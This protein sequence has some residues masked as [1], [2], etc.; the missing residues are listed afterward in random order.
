MGV[1]LEGEVPIDMPQPE[2]AVPPPLLAS[3]AIMRKCDLRCK[4]CY[5]DATEHPDADELSTSEAKRLVDDLS[6][7]GV[8]LLVLDGGEPLCRDDLLKDSMRLFRT[9]QRV[10]V[11][12]NLGKMAESPLHAPML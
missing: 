5:S 8:R 2:T 12:K 10:H 1:A 9:E 6:Q 3:Y 7:L 11:G 4:H